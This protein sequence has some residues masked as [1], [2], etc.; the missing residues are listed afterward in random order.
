[1]RVIVMMMMMMKLLG[2]DAK[3]IFFYRDINNPDDYE[4][5]YNLYSFDDFL[6]SNGIKISDY[7]VQKILNRDVTHCCSVNQDGDAWLVSDCNY[8]SLYYEASESLY[9]E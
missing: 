7:E 8:G 2:N 3:T 1:M 5:F 9:S 6:R 4:E